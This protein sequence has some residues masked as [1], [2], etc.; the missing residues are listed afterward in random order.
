MRRAGCEA[1]YP[2]EALSVMGLAEVLRHLPRLLRL[3][4]EFAE[5]LL[6]DPPDVFCGIDSPDFNLPLAARL[7]RAGIK[8][9]QYVSPQVWAW[10]QSRVKSIGESVDQVLCVLPFETDFYAEHGVDA[11]FVGHPLLEVVASEMSDK[12]F[13][14][15]YGLDPGKPILAVLPGSRRQEIDQILPD[16]LSAAKTIAHER[17]MQVAIGIAPTLEEGYFRTM[18]KTEGVALVRGATYELMDHAS[19]AMVTSGTATLET[20]MFATPMVVVYKTSWVTYLLGRLLIRVKNI[21]LVNI[22]AGKTIVPELIQHRATARNMAQE[23][24]DVFEEDGRI[25]TMKEELSKVRELLGSS[26]ASRIVCQTSGSIPPTNAL[27]SKLG[28]EYIA[29]TSPFRGSIAMTAPRYAAGNCSR[30]YRCSSRSRLSRMV[31]PGRASEPGNTPI[32]RTSRPRAS[33]SSN[34]RPSIPRRR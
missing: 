26:G 2:S 12:D 25:D 14:K 11:K 6:A 27:G 1:W 21:G 34:R 8:T 18:H 5:R 31:S 28:T 15:R 22:V 30:A 7:R 17:D 9:V 20:A 3:R 10:R 24:M 23:I 19:F 13:R 32:S 16:M 33:T 29:R 4:R